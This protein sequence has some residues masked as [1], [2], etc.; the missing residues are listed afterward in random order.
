MFLTNLRRLV[1]IVFFY[2]VWLFLAHRG[3]DAPNSGVFIV[4]SLIFVL[5]FHRNL[6]LTAS[7]F[8]IIGAFVDNLAVKTLG[9]MYLGGDNL[10]PPVWLIGMWIIFVPFLIQFKNYRINPLIFA[11]IFGAG[12]TLAGSALRS[13][14]SL[15]IENLS[16]LALLWSI[17]GGLF[18]LILRFWQRH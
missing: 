11:V 2:G 9:G 18:S 13:I 1:Y 5:I 10:L 17:Y 3:V 8:G 4:V 12:G 14:G 15:Q 6:L 16:L 7:V